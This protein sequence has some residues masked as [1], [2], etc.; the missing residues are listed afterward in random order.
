MEDARSEIT[1]SGMSPSR[2]FTKLIARNV[3]K[4]IERERSLFF[5]SNH[6]RYSVHVDKE[7][8]HYFSC[9]IEIQIGAREWSG[10][11]EGRSVMEAVLNTLKRL[12]PKNLIELYR[13]PS[14][15]TPIHEVSA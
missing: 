15:P 10:M 5:L 8:R 12:R 13:P 14:L 3:E 6:T 2:T 11:S 9:H 1:F 7:T 4:W